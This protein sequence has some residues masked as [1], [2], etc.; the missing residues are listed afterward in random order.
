[1]RTKDSI[2]FERIYFAEI[3]KDSDAPRY[4][5]Y[6]RA[7]AHYFDKYNKRKY[8]SW[9]I[10]RSVVSRRRKSKKIKK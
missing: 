8:V 2:E 3:L 10:F 6:I 4:V 7:E 5:C 9:A 1:M